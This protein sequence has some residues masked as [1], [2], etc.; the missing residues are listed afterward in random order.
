MN[1]ALRETVSETPMAPSNDSAV[2]IAQEWFAE[3][4]AWIDA[5]GLE[6]YDPFDVKQH[7]WIRA[8]QPRPLL[9]KATTGLCDLAPVAAR[10]LL[11]T[12]P[13]KNPKA[14][15]LVAL[16][17]LRL[18]QLTGE[19]A[20]LEAAEQHL[21][22][23]LAHPTEYSPGLSWGYPFDIHAKGL[24]T[25]R[26]TPI[27]VVTAIAG[28]AFCRAATLT[29]DARY[30]DIVRRISAFMISGLPRLSWIG[31]CY[32]FAYTPSDRRRVHNASLLV[33]EH[34]YRAAALLDEPS[35]AEAA[36]PALAFTLRE[37]REDGAWRYGEHAPGDPYEAG[38]LGLVDHHHTGFVLRS[39]QAIRDIT[40]DDSLVPVIRRGFDFY[41]KHLLLP[42]GMPVN[43]YGHYPVDIHACAEAVLCPSALQRE[44]L[45]ARGLADLP[46]RWTHYYLRDPRNGLPWYRKYP[47]F[48][49][50]I[51]FPRWGTA[52]MY[53]ALAEYLHARC[54]TTPH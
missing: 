41:R 54:S 30:F 6:G 31:G 45:A 23:L 20:A 50:R 47:R 14:F 36:A 3:L 49:S 51:H 25:P 5:H 26:G 11:G 38:L 22:W 33:A 15:A 27:S 13:A 19:P 12:A 32:C 44:V 46:L 8:A 9:R 48:T 37:Q 16:G 52:W 2:A 18:Y 29:G 4:N 17:K 53:C 42:T 7:P 40:G 39:L 28:Q 35:L 10:R 1:P 21:H 34:L 43:D 24:D